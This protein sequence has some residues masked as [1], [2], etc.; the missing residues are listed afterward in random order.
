MLIYLLVFLIVEILAVLSCKKESSKK[1]KIAIYPALIVII[2]SIFG[3]LRDL[4]IGTD[5]LVYGSNW[6]EIATNFSSLSS[7]INYIDSSDV[8]Y[9]FINYVVSRFTSD[10]NMFLIVLQII[11]NGLVVATLYK[12]RDKV[13]FWLSL[14]VYL[15]VFYCRTF[16]IL[17]QAIALSLV[18]YAIRFLD[19]NRPIRFIITVLIASTFH[20]T[21]IVSLII[22]LFRKICELSPRF[23]TMF[24]V[25]IVIITFIIVFFIKDMISIL[26]SLGIVNLRIYNYLYDFATSQFSVTVIELVFKV[27]MLALVL[28]QNKKMR[29]NFKLNNLLVL[30]AI[31]DFVIYQI[32]S[33][34]MYSDRLSFYFGYFLMLIFPQA[35]V[36][37]KAKG[38]DKLVL[39]CL[40]AVFLL[41]YWY[42]KFVYSGSCEV[43]PYSSQVLGI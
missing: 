35:A 18:F 24:V 22:I 38:R 6:F 20:F 12:Y 41:G 1:F 15:C 43:Y 23:K 27:L 3:G 4:T 39:N 21:A 10:V 19:E 8:G 17:R 30:C 29:D 32:R 40:F 13:P 7:Y 11:C 9:L 37:L 31:V 26:Y 42:Y 5:V 25:I 2:L 36:S 33:V 16:N 34:I 28:L 14:L